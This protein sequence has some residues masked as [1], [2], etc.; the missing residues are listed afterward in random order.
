MAD[1]TN[2]GQPSDDASSR[3]TPVNVSEATIQGVTVTRMDV[4]KGHIKELQTD[5]LEELCKCIEEQTETLGGLLVK[6]KEE[7]AGAF[8]G[9]DRDRLREERE[10][11]KKAAQ[12]DG[13]TYNER[14][15]TLLQTLVSQG[16]A[17]GGGGGGDDGGGG[18]E[19]RGGR[20]RARATGKEFD[21]LQK[22]LEDGNLAITKW[23][24]FFV[25][26]AGVQFNENID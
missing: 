19:D 24:Q 23:H 4:N 18:G 12:Q 16:A 6:A 9:S 2:P 21:F 1:P 13:G 3:G 17:S 7:I 8:E 26:G 11:R 10:G 5:L 15:L 25:R 22:N 14:V 20:A